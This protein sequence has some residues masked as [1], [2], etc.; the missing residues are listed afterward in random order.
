MVD[1]SDIPVF[2]L[3][4][5]LGTRLKEHTEFRPKPMVEVGNKPIIWHIMRGYSRFGFKKFV[6]C[7]G[8]RSDV[9]KDYFLQYDARNSDFTVKL[10]THDVRYHN[11]HHEED[12]SVTVAYTGEHTM[13]GA[14]IARAASRY[15]GTAEHFAVTYGDGLCNADLLS[16]L[17]AHVTT[18]AVGTVLAINPPSRFGELRM[19][20]SRVV[21]FA[22]KPELSESW[23]NG[24][25]FL[26]RRKF[27]EY[28]SPEEDCVLEQQ[29]LRQLADS[30]EL[31]AFRHSGFWACM[32][33]QRD[34]E[35][36]DELWNSG[37]A[38][39]AFPG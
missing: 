39:W 38:P 6:V 10:K 22:E 33:T 27:L 31:H 1:P 7:T 21:E 25:Y 3:A 20:S 15:L 12:W 29:P 9:I 16:V 35:Y 8:F 34:K 17:D 28:L 30:G 18:G 37:R 14:R 24:G 2:I 5:G 13:T 11:S 32:D 23:I 26:F 4:G 19:Q 36:L